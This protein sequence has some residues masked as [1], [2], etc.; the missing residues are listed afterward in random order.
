MA[1]LSNPI[2]F[3]RGP[4]TVLT[5]LIYLA[6]IVILLIIQTGVPSIPRSA[7]PTRDINLTEAWHDLQLLTNSYHP[8]NSRQNDYVHDWLKLRLE[9]IIIEN[10]ANDS[11]ARPAYVFADDKSNLT[12]S[13]PVSNAGGGIS[14]YFESRNLVVIIPGK[15]D[16]R[17]WW[18]Q[19]NGSPKKR[20]GV[21][22]NAHY[23]S[24]SS[25]FGATDDGMGIITIMQLLKYYTT[26]GNQ[27]KHP[28]V[29]LL[30][31]GEEDFL[32]GARVFS[33]H[34]MAKL[35]SSFLNL[36][37]AGAG[38][39][40]VLFRSTDTEITKAYAKSPYPF[41]EVIFSDGFKRGLIRSQTD[42]VIFNG[43]L[44]YRGLD[45]AFL[46]PRARYHTKEDNTQHTN[47]ASIWHMLSSALATTKAL[48]SKPLETNLDPDDAPGTPAVWFDLLGRYMVVFQTPTLFALSITLLVAGPVI[49]AITMAILR[50]ADKLY[51]FSGSRNYHRTDGDE[52]VPLYGWRGFFRFPIVLMFACAAPVALAYLLFKENEFIVHSSEWAVW[53]MMV[54][55]FIF[56]SWFLCRVADFGRPSALTRLYGLTWMW[57]AWWVVL[58]G[59]TVF[60]ERL[61]IAG[62][63]WILIFAA[64]IWL[65]T[66]LSYLELFSLPKKTKYCLEKLGEG[67]T[68]RSQSAS[69]P[70]QDDDAVGASGQT[71]AENND[72][73]E[74]TETSG[75]LGNRGRSSFRKYTQAAMG[76]DDQKPEDHTAT[77]R[78]EEQEWSSSQ[79]SWTWILQIL[80]IIPFNLIVIGQIALSIVAGLH[81]TG[82]D[83]SSVFLV[84]LTI[85]IFTIILFS[86]MVP[87]IHR[88][89]WHVPMFLFLV[90]IGTLIYNL[91]AFPFSENNRLKLFFQQ[92]VDIH[93]G[94]NNVSLIG[95][96]HYVQRAISN[97]PSSA[98]VELDCYKAEDFSD[99]RKCTWTGLPPMVTK[100]DP[101]LP[102]R[103]A[104]RS[105]MSF[106]AK[107]TFNSTDNGKARFAVHG[108]DTRACKIVFD[109]PIRK[110]KVKGQGPND[111]RFAPVPDGGSKEVRLW[112]R[113]WNTTWTVDVKWDHKANEPGLKGKVVCMWSDV[114][115]RGTIPAYDEALHFLPSWTALTKAGDGL[116]EAFERFSV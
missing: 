64:T 101:N 2:A 78:H 111:P 49:L 15:D 23:D 105:L 59:A 116:V 50:R 30:N 95:A 1:K 115:Q 92:E 29:L 47:K 27:P 9:T 108:K 60:E 13:T 7:T 96:N 90:L 98:G 102:P 88:F 4:V 53:S 28:I 87:F 68:S 41:G 14:V 42:Y 86:P 11:S 91:I 84:Y 19:P 94:Y 6:I 22:V 110:F 93:T 75:L 39:R 40:A 97:L 16:T 26:P 31:D 70:A 67:A 46:E 21:L 37:G 43:I 76:D 58:V 24:V 107:R 51:M 54:S 32:N 45:V 79:W 3:T 44:G 33:Q 69:C 74:A 18:R 80:I 52:S 103:L 62:V 113:S 25:G 5:S 81:Q 106:S 83:G 10:T 109:S 100:I 38:G 82:A 73:E 35:V 114:N 89:T 104:Y 99:R 65:A 57:A 36:E 85:A 71:E 17:E 20:N 77:E 112:S 63:Y 61:H 72:E 55:S 34:P 12:F 8:Y 66:F 56:V 48:S